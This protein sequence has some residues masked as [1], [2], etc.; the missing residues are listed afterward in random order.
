VCVC[1]CLKG[2]GADFD[3]P[4]RIEEDIN[5]ASEQTFVYICI[6]I[7]LVLC[8]YLFYL[9]LLICSVVK[10]YTYI[11]HVTVFNRSKVNMI[12]QLKEAV[13]MLQDPNR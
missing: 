4:L 3:E 12:N 6:F 11:Y 9:F 13:E 5:W 10:T 7:L 8:L 2:R 1:V